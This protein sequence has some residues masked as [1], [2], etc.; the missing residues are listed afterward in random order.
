MA[1]IHN[2]SLS[3]NVIDF[4]GTKNRPHCMLLLYRMLKKIYPLACRIGNYHVYKPQLLLNFTGLQFLHRNIKFM[5]RIAFHEKKM[6]VIIE[7]PEASYTTRGSDTKRIRKSLHCP[8]NYEGWTTSPPTYEPICI[9]PWTFQNQLN[10]APES[11]YI[12]EAVCYS[13]SKSQKNHKMENQ[14]LLDSTWVDIYSE[15]II[16]H[17]LF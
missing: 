17:V 4:S 6:T 11:G 3:P 15:H 13:N 7:Q 5:K 1:L 2:I 14:I 8:L 16:W 9:T 12:T 10:C